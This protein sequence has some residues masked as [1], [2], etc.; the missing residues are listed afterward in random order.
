MLEG[1]L[2]KLLAAAAAGEVGMLSE[3]THQ[4]E[5]TLHFWQQGSILGL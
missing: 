1:E 3:S 4:G 5:G 2:G